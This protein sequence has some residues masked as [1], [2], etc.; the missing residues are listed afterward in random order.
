MAVARA[1]RGDPGIL[2]S[3]GKA[4]SSVSKIPIVGQV[5]KAIPGVG[6]AV[7]LG[8]AAYE[9]AKMIGK[10]SAS[11]PVPAGAPPAVQMQLQNAVATKFAPSE[12]GMVPGGWGDLAKRGINV[13][14]GKT[15]KAGAVWKKIGTGV[16]GVFVWALIDKATGAIL[17]QQDHPPHRR[18]NPMNVKAL[19]RA[20][21]RV[22]AFAGISRGVLR[23]LGYQVSSTRRGKT[24]KRRGK[25][26]R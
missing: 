24:T 3:V 5:V 22:C 9:A 14:T 8:A 21:R 23:D 20:D 7:S 18:M 10:P 6:T 1:H 19:R 25:R 12:M 13:L 2:Q 4:L 26:C 15:S 11:V 17:K 16:A